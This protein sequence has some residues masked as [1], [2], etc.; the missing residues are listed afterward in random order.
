MFGRVDT[1]MDGREAVEMVRKLLFETRET[2]DIIIVDINMPSMSGAEICKK[3]K[4]VVKRNSFNQMKSPFICCSSTT[5]DKRAF[6]EA[7]KA[8]ANSILIKPIFR[9]SLKDMLQFSGLYPT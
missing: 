3:I 7:F 9:N 6:D 2:Y 8:G 1:A 5:K 4:K